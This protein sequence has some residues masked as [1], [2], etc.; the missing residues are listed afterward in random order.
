M[1]N[2]SYLPDI[3]KDDFLYTMGLLLRPWQWTR[4]G[5]ETKL[6]KKIERFFKGEKTYLMSSGRGALW[7]LLKA[8]DLKDNDEIAIQGFTCCAVV[9]PVISLNLK[10]VYVDIN[11]KYNLDVSDF[12]K[13]ITKKTKAVIVQHTFGVPADIVKIRDICKEKNI[14][15]VEDLAH[16]W[17][18]EVNKMKL[19]SFGDGAVLS[20]GRTKV[21]SSMFGGAVVIN[22]DEIRK[23]VGQTVRVLEYPSLWFIFKQLN[24]QVMF[25][26]VKS[27]YNF[28]NIG[29]S[30]LFLAAKLEL[31]SKEVE[32]CEKKGEMNV[33][34][35]RKMPN[36]LCCLGL[37]QADKLK[38]FAKIRKKYG[39]YYIN[40]L[41]KDRFQFLDV[42]ASYLR[43]P[44]E[45]DYK[46]ELID[47]AKKKGVYLGDWYSEVVS[48][49]G[50]KIRKMK[51]K[52]GSCP[53][54]ERVCKRV[55]NL[56]TN[57][58]LKMKDIKKVI[59][60]LNEFKGKE[61]KREE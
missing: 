44:V 8:L 37:S 61:D 17:G 12:E 35:Q 1:I 14:F 23:R 52:R 58:N 34:L 16:S 6:K 4:G 45:V 11:E 47:Y 19:G 7:V 24:H 51:Y 36:T 29:K 32:D 50:V 3:E 26:V 60:V 5:C 9:N 43:F 20:F 31:T 10:P 15:L 54:A 46:E 33:Q 42:E 39:N 30:F 56:P 28:L 21:I 59:E 41:D 40:N 57:P 53:K 48:P 18:G 49:S 22:G 25:C 13:K 2:I 38:K 27:F 55:I